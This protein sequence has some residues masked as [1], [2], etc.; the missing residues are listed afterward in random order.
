MLEPEKRPIQK[1]IESV[2]AL[3]K[4]FMNRATGGKEMSGCNLK[5]CDWI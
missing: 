2:D 5:Y 1:G 3:P 4:I